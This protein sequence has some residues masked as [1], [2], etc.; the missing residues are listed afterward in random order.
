VLSTCGNAGVGMF[1]GV[2]ASVMV[3][4]GFGVVGMPA[5]PSYAAPTAAAPGS[6]AAALAEARDSGER[7]EIAAAT[8]E[9]RQ[10]FAN[11][12][13]TL[14][15]EQTARPA[16]VRQGGGWVP[17]DLR[18]ERRADGR[19]APVAATADVSFSGGGS[20]PLARIGRG[21]TSL[22]LAWPEPLPQ[23]VVD[24]D[25]ATYADVLPGVDLVVHAE[26]DSFSEVLVV[27]TPAAAASPELRALR[28]ATEASGVRLQVGESGGFDAVDAA[29]V[30]V[31]SSPEPLAWDSSGGTEAPASAV[32][33]STKSA[34]GAVVA[35]SAED[36][37]VR[38]PQDGDRVVPMTVEVG[39]GSVTVRPDAAL[40]GDPGVRFPLYLDPTVGV[41]PARTLWAMVNKSFPGTSSVNWGN[42]QNNQG[43]GVGYTNR[44]GVHTKRLYWMF[45]TRPIAGK[46]IYQS[47]FRPFE[48]HADSCTKSQIKLE[49][50]SAI[51][52]STNWTNQPTW[53]EP[54]SSLTTAVGRNECRPG[55]ERLEF[56]AKHAATRAAN[57]RWPSATLRLIAGTE[58]NRVGWKRFRNDAQWS[59][60]YNTP[61]P[62]PVNIRTTSPATSCVI[63]AG[64]PSIPLDPPILTALLT[65]ADSAKQQMQAHFELWQ[66]NGAEIAERVTEIKKAGS[67]TWPL[68]LL[69]GDKKL[70]EGNYSWRVRAG[71]TVTWSGFSRWCEFTVDSTA[72]LQPAV[73]APEG[74]RYEVGS[75]AMFTFASGGSA[76]VASYRWSLTTR[77]T[78]APVPA[79]SPTVSVPL[80]T[81][82][83]NVLRVWSYDRAGNE[84]P[85]G[86]FDFFVDGGQVAGRWRLDEGS[87]TV[88]HDTATPAHPLTL[89]GGVSWQTGRW[90]DDA[91][92]RALGFNGTNAVG[93]TASVDVVR[94]DENFSVA[95][96]VKPSDI[97]ARRSAVSKGETA[98]S[99]F[100]LG[101]VPAG[102]DPQTLPASF[103]FTL[104][105]TDPAAPAGQRE[106][107][108]R[109]DQPALVDEWVHLI[110]VYEAGNQLLTLYVNGEWAASTEVEF[111]PANV[112]GPLRIGRA[113]TNAPVPA[114][115]SGDLDEVT[116]FAGALD[117]A[118]AFLLASEV[119]PGPTAVRRG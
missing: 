101:V 111:T 15:M 48:T 35:G 69:P 99:G 93:A 33:E 78:S 106:A 19:I 22:S 102:P 94:T 1:R 13:G 108:A 117:E 63:G 104:A 49:L 20:A 90:P 109:F 53:K 65:D 87:G 105:N 46:V 85:G 113:Q 116:A 88:A 51:S 62:A 98:A 10:V 3:A 12:S 25:T 68:D 28:F 103:A 73:T 34:A 9:T 24:Q 55:G 45:D 72:P 43:E 96:W 112:T 36:P 79:A 95:A 86:T 32:T 61:P 5:A 2:L 56:D 81:F 91:T 38:A 31:F 30:P 8:T 23:P 4:V 92:D 67:F 74:Q 44:E 66:T 118:Q 119:R 110:G 60:E 70:R 42:G 84:S 29:G 71:D 14:T 83:R 76:D 27:K 114:F 57:G 64:R 17:V 18:L 16:R 11:P 37:R 41:T 6:E 39:A 97:A 82:G 52:R 26:V 80:K 59:V 100:T 107:V 21:A 7:V 40:L 58:T 115:W 50:T 89:S 47:K 75:P 77:P 54:V